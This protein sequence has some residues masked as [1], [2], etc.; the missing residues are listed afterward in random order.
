VSRQGDALGAAVLRPLGEQLIAAMHL[1]PGA[2]VCELMCDGGV[3]SSALARALPVDGTLVLTDTDRAMLE[4]VAAQAGGACRIEARVIDGP[5]I[6]LDDASCD[7]LTSLLTLTFAEAGALLADARRVLRPG[8][9]LAVVVWDAANPP[10]HEAA[11]DAA[12]RANGV[13]SRFMQRVLAPVNAPAGVAQTVLHDVARL[14]TFA[15]LWAA[16][17]DQRPLS[18]EL[19]AL[20]EAVVTAMRRDHEALLMRFAAADGTLRVPLS[21]RLLSMRAGA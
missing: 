4:G 6:P 21:A 12:L 2:V 17:V 5:R 20:D 13:T 16:C 19:A 15:H 8:G 1:E 7:A 14:E 9:S 10:A 18:D 11:L 3:L